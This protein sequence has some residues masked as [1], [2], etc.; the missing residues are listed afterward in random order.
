MPS[1]DALI[2]FRCMKEL[3]TRLHRL[4]EKN[5]RSP[6]DFYRFIMAEYADQQEKLLKLP[7]MTP[8]ESDRYLLAAEEP[9][10]YKT[11]KLS[12][13]PAKLKTPTKN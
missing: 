9:V 12:R 7:P 2:K 5:R 10:P 6:S 1:Y 11:G 3:V 8:A 4:A 13:R